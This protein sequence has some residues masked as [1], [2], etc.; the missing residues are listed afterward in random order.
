[1][2]P[3]VRVNGGDFSLATQGLQAVNGFTGTVD[4][5]V[6]GCRLN[7][8]CTLN[9]TSMTLP[10]GANSSLTVWTT[11]TTPGGTYTLTVHG[12][13][14]QLGPNDHGHVTIPDFSISRWR[15][16]RSPLA[17]LLTGQA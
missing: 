7:S 13:Q 17:P 8:A 1:M 14:R 10:P 6:S 12:N 2:K 5:S 16:K 11:S 15:R 4:L 9:P 3:G